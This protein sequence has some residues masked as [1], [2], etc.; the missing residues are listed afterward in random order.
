[1]EAY[2][3]RSTSSH[4]GESL[5]A[6]SA[7]LAKSGDWA[8]LQFAWRRILDAADPPMGV[9]HTADFLARYPG[10]RPLVR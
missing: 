7:L 9:L 6:M 2:A 10:V 5:Y 4:Q 1:M 8:K 3:D